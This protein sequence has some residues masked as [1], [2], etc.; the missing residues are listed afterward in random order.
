MEINERFLK[1]SSRL[2]YSKDIELG[3][4]I[5]LTIDGLPVIANCVKL[6]QLDKQNGTIDVVYNLKFLSE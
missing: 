1:F 5:T 3:Q 4:D 2:P 6:D